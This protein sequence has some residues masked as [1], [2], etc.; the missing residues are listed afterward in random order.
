[1]DKVYTI[2]YGNSNPHVGVFE[3]SLLKEVLPLSEDLNLLD[4]SVIMSEV[5]D[6]LQS[7]TIQ[8]LNLVNE[9]KRLKNLK[10][11]KS[12]LDM[13]INYSETLGDD[14]LA[15]A[16]GAY[17]NYISDSVSSI[18][19][20]DAGTFLTIDKVTKNGF[21]GGFI[22]PGIKTFLSSY[23][24]A[25]LLPELDKSSFEH[26]SWTWGTSTNSAILEATK[27]YL[28]GVYHEVFSKEQA[29]LV[30]LTGGESEL[31][32]DLLETIVPRKQL[33]I[34]QHLIH[35]SLFQLHKD[36]AH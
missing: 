20:I 23:G 12:I 13:P 26:T 8:N 31:H 6:V 3:N 2:D 7:S 4:G 5:G 30:L 28:K 21:E 25:R 35:E 34:Q 10:K 32:M 18:Y 22:L 36:S 33:K 1:M 29:D 19:I 24:Q 27:I 9:I 17:K 16:Y 11:E 14:R 15:V